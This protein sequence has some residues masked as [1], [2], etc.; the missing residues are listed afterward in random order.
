MPVIARK[1]LIKL[2]RNGDLAVSPILSKKQIGS[3]SIDLR[4]GNVAAIV[5]ARGLSHVDPKAYMAAN[6]EHKKEK[7]KRQKLDKH[8]IPFGE[9]LLLHPGTLTLVPTFEWV[10]LPYNLQGVVTA[11][12]S[13]AREGLNIATA[14]FINPEYTGIITLELANLGQIPIAL[15]PGMRIAQIAFYSINLGEEDNKDIVH[16]QFDMAFEPEMGDIAKKDD[17]YFTDDT[18]TH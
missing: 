4:M 10:K 1:N 12:S 16:S 5:R 15:Y 17:D 14:S 18:D 7:E 6:T 11:R 3:C 13:W 2:I 9:A 8:E